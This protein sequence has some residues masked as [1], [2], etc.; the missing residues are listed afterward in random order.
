VSDP[1]R[2]LPDDTLVTRSRDG[3]PDALAEL[4]RRHAGALLRYV[5]RLT[6]ERDAAEDILQE[7]FLRIFERRGRYLGRGRFRSWLFTVATRQAR[8]RART[9]R[10][11]GELTGAFAGELAPR[12]DGDPLQRVRRLEILREIESALA[13][14]PPAYAATFQL[15]ICESFSYREISEML[16][17]P[18][19]TLRSRVHHALRRVR[20]ALEARGEA[21]EP[22]PTS[23]AAEQEVR[24]RAPRDR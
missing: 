24:R 18:E 10:R 16:D 22:R 2:E 8:D 1:L 21:R 3:D 19:G 20:A 11:R 23:G 9:A 14:L 6:G 7:T 15:R 4:Y 13:D 17:E 5:E 12:P